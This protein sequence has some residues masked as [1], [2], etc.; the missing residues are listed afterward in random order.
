MFV[1]GDNSSA[2]ECNENEEPGNVG[3]GHVKMENSAGNVE[4]EN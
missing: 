2:M 3:V 1:V 4:Q